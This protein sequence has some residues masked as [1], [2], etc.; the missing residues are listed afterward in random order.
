MNINTINGLLKLAL[1]TPKEP[2]QS[3]RT[4]INQNLSLSETVQ[5]AI[6]ITVVG[7]FLP[8]VSNLIDPIETQS[9]FGP[10]LSHPLQMF[11]MQLFITF[12]A[13]ALVMGLGRLNRGY[14]D[15]KDALTA[16]V[17]LQFILLG[18]QIL[19]FLLAFMFPTLSILVF[20]AS[21]LLMLYLSVHFIMEIHGFTNPIAVTFGVMAAFF[22]L[23]FIL[24]IILTLLGFTPEAVSNV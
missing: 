14:G 3:L 13:A 19:Q 22:G 16:V 15:F 24:S 12:A 23:A 17:W 5:A 6:F 2:K 9:P 20:M 8:M 18:I 7:M 10:M 11:A 1:A 4:L 21:L